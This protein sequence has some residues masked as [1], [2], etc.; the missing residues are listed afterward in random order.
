VKSDTRPVDL[1][2]L[3]A[4]LDDELDEARR[5][6]VERHLADH[7]EAA[8]RHVEYRRRDEALRLAFAQLSVDQAKC[9]TPRVMQ[10]RSPGRRR[11]RWA[12]AAAMLGVILG[13]AGWW[14][15]S[16][17]L[18]DRAL[19]TLAQEAV[20]A[21]LLYASPTGQSPLATGDSQLVSTRLSA[22]LG[23]GV[24]APNLST[25]GLRLVGLREL[26]S[27][28]GPAALL[29]YRDASGREV[30]CYFIRVADNRETRFAHWE[31][32]GVNVLDRFD[33]RL[34]YAVVGTLPLGALRQ[35]AEA[36]YLQSSGEGPATER[37]E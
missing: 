35:I 25:F 10:A 15:G 6:A 24:K 22:L 37:T 29:V 18:E 17:T 12:I 13:S 16:S 33:D 5:A 26:P 1:E 28:R 7:A 32:A 34:G 19:A 27:D 36:G 20:T 14:Y 9:P 11:F 23:G 31:T 4:Y 8:T 3:N 30:S 21:H 2:D